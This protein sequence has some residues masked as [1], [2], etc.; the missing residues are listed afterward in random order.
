MLWCVLGD[1]SHVGQA[2]SLAMPTPIL[3]RSILKSDF[4]FDVLTN[5]D[6][7]HGNSLAVSWGGKAVSSCQLPSQNLLIPSVV[8]GEVRQAVG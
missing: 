1:D 7:T 5:I 8:Q 6:P 2:A 3:L 4:N